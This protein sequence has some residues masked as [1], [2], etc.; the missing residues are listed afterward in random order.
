MTD[1]YVEINLSALRANAAGIIARYPGYRAYIGVVKGDAYGHGMRAA[2]A[3]AEG[4]INLFAVSSMEE[5][6]E[7]RRYTDADILLLEP[8]AIDRIGEA[9]DLCLTLPISDSAYLRRFL[10]AAGEYSF[11][12][13]L[14]IDA[15]F[16]R[17][18]FDNPDEIREAVALMKASPHT[19]K[20]VYQHFATAGI[21][22]PHYDE[23]IRRF[24]VLTSEI[25]LSEIP[26]VHLTSGVTMLAHPRIDLATATR[27]GLVL[28][29]YNVAPTSYGS[30]LKD[31]VR[32]MRDR[33]YRKKYSLTPTITDVDLDLTPAMT[34]RCRILQIK[35]VEEGEHIGYGAAY[36]APEHCRIAILPV[37]YNNGI[38]HA[39]HGR[40]VQIGDR[41]Y[42]VVGEIGM[43]MLA[44]KVDER[45]TVDDEAI[46]LGGRIT[47]GMFSRAAGLGLAEALV[48]IGKN[49]P[50]TYIE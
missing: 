43:N 32:E 8:V 11:P 29:G 42:P 45:V 23:Q 17:L 36:T 7:L 14:Q 3:L 48:M 40:V 47:L 5:A 24:R 46:L 26:L 44:V 31:Q 2:A 9:H 35:T 15:G 28:Y 13:H 22:D 34:F 37:G 6:A 41:L 21:N 1:S 4:G 18:G 19:L 38:G 30:G 50:R 10:D 20:G 33:Y 49:N 39:N 16:H 25:D 27:M 12:L